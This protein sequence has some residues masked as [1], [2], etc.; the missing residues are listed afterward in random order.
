MVKFPTVREG[1]GCDTIPNLIERSCQR[2][3]STVALQQRRGTQ[4]I[5]F[6]YNELFDLIK[7][8]AYRLE[9]NKGDRVA[10]VGENKP[11]WSISCLGIEWAGGVVVPIDPR[12][13]PNEHKYILENSGSRLA[14][15][16]DRFM[17][18]FS[19]FIEELD[20]FTRVLPMDELTT[21]CG[22]ESLPKA[23]ISLDDLAVILYTSG[24]TGFSKGV[25]LTHC[26]LGSNLDS[27]YRC[28]DFGEGDNFFSVLPLHHVFEI[29]VDFL[30][31]LAAGATITYSR[32]LKS[33]EI[34]EDMVDTGTTVFIIVPLFLEKLLQSIL[35]SIAQLPPLRKSLLTTLKGTSR[36]FDPI[37]H[38]R[39]SKTL[40]KTVR[41]EAGFEKMKYII[42]GGAPLAAEVSHGL[43]RFGFPIF[44]GY[45]LSE[46]SP[47]LTVNPI[48]A[49]KNESVGLP[50]PEVELK[51]M[52]PDPRGIG[53]IA[54]RGSNIMPGYY[55]N[56]EATKLVFTS[57][58]W[59]L[60]GD[61]GWI[62][63]HG[64][65]Y[66]VGRKK[67][68][69]V[70][71]GGKNV[72]PEEVESELLRSPFIEEVIVVGGK[73]Q[74]EAIIYP[75]LEKLQEYASQNNLELNDELVH[76]LIKDEVTK[77]CANIAD[78]KRIRRFTL[79]NEPFPKTTTEKIKRYLFE[80]LPIVV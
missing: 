63:T 34:H 1:I 69:I 43:E 33:S 31:P 28:F 48:S 12:L 62:D 23:H 59:F 51:I 73:R 6:T 60:T 41:R 67:S 13:T 45:G 52:N 37:S 26:N 49:P 27:I 72:Y 19:G 7:Q 57:D 32:S 11:E 74:I 54:A 70:T 9:I 15:V 76:K 38:C 42:S 53:E 10:I 20:T 35:K 22:P 75:N 2:F 44:Q 30:A 5:Q 24:T 78:Y 4:W 68:V 66:I 18:E 14:I 36:L 61:V 8:L 71:P 77:L 25:M 40:L 21:T 79:R 39:A 47:V 56:E 16:S 64:Y 65:L 55:K 58:D 46:T 50:I 80:Q 17:D 29:T 3:P